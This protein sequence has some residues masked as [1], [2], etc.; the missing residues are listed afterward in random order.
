[1]K[2]IPK[3]SL[4]VRLHQFGEELLPMLR[5]SRHCHHVTDPIVEI[6]ERGVKTVQGEEHVDI[7]VY[8]IGSQEMNNI[9]N[10]KN[11]GTIGR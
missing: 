9:D 5:N 10:L 8:A 6:T 4:G 2:S 7:I 3:Y 11:Y 1:M